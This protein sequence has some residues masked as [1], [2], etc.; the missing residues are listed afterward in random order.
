[1]EAI[2]SYLC[3]V[4][5]FQKEVTYSDVRR[6]QH[7]VA[8]LHLVVSMNRKLNETYRYVKDCVMRIQPLMRYLLVNMKKNPFDVNR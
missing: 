3:K 7:I 8:A 2:I 5:L 4:A 1:M 6:N